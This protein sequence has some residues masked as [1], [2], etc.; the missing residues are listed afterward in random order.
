MTVSL[1]FDRPQSNDV[2]ATERQQLPGEL[3][4]SL[5][6][7]WRPRQAPFAASFVASASS[8]LEYDVMTVRMLLKSWA[9]P[10]ASV[11]IASIFCDCRSCSSRSFR[12][13]RSVK[14]AIE[15]VLCPLASVSGADA[16]SMSIG[17]PS[18]RVDRTSTSFPYPLF[19]V[20]RSRERASGESR[21]PE[22][23][24]SDRAPR[25]LSSQTGSP[26]RDST[27][28]R[29]S[30]RRPRRLPGVPRRTATAILPLR[31][32]RHVQTR[33]GP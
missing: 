12:S 16:M 31:M 33:A 27:V 23:D 5:A 8:M 28:S 19:S 1:M 20:A 25:P 9:M 32:K 17:V 21:A 29:T 15:P 14:T 30:L 6:R 24:S 26:L 7:P 11:P 18:C 2:P 22:R 13:V 3:G 4:R 10:P